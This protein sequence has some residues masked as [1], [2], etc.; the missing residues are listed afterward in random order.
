[1]SGISALI[2]ACKQHSLVISWYS[3]THAP[4]RLCFESVE[5]HQ[6]NPHAH[7][8]GLWCL[9]IL[10]WQRSELNLANLWWMWQYRMRAPTSKPRMITALSVA[11]TATITAVG[12]ERSANT[13]EGYFWVVNIT[14]CVPGIF[15]THS[16][17]Y[18]PIPVAI[19]QTCPLGIPR[20]C[21]VRITLIGGHRTCGCCIKAAHPISNGDTPWVMG[22]TTHIIEGPGGDRGSL[23]C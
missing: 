21:V 17:W 4:Y 5:H 13:I 1:M 7:I 16:A 8:V 14:F 12:V 20:Q 6:L 9:S 22:I 18:T 3:D 10:T 23:A 15:F 2:H 19:N 11:T